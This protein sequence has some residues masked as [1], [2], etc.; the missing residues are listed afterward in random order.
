ML[1]EFKP[2][3]VYE[4]DR[5][6]QL[7]YL[8][9]NIK[10][11]AHLLDR[12][13]CPQGYSGQVFPL[14]ASVQRQLWIITELLRQQKDMHDTRSHH[15]PGRIVSL[16][17]P[18]VRPI[19]RGKAGKSVEFGAKLSVS[20]VEGLV[21]M[22]HLSWDNF[23]ESGDLLPQIETYKERFGCYPE[24][25]LADKIYWSRENRAVC[26]SLDI[27]IGGAPPLGRPVKTQAGRAQRRE[28]A[29]KATE[30]NRIEGRFGVAKRAFSLDRIFAKT[31]ATSENWI[32]MILMVMNLEKVL[33]DLFLPV[34]LWLSRVLDTLLGVW[35]P[36]GYVDYEQYLPRKYANKSE[37]RLNAAF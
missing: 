3:S 32:A 15:T 10:H 28:E 30:R 37:M 34:F 13:G 4:L 33:K 21:Y 25:V 11:I 22:D 36:F 7:G 8:D 16:S 5:N 35:M 19:V 12:L 2:E 9:R 26:Q 14:P 1:Y 29:K 17:Q 31:R 23:N 6:N 27:K 20:Y 18:H 24:R